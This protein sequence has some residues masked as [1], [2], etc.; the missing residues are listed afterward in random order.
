MLPV[1]LFNRTSHVDVIDH[2]LISIAQWA[3][4]NTVDAAVGEVLLF[5]RFARVTRSATPDVPVVRIGVTAVVHFAKSGAEVTVVLEML[6]QSNHIGQHRTPRI[7]IV[8]DTC[9]RRPQP[10]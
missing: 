1:D 9:R 8:V 6:W 4:S 7:R 3:K 5:R 2:L 10:G